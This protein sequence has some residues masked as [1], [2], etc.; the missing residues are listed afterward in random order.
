MSVLRRMLLTW[1]QADRREWQSE[2]D[3]EK[4]RRD[5][6]VRGGPDAA[7][8]FYERIFGRTPAFEDDSSAPFKFGNTLVNL[9]TTRAAGDVIAPVVVA[10]PSAGSRFLLT[11]WVDDVDRPALSLPIRE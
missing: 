9:V 10:S 5:H 11:I 6:A 2:R 8:S 3:F 7:R 1:Q 4:R